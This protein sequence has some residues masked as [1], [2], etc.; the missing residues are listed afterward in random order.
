MQPPQNTAMGGSRAPPPQLQLANAQ[1]SAAILPGQLSP[2]QQVA[3]M[4]RGTPPRPPNLNSPTG[5]HFAVPTGPAINLQMMLQYVQQQNPQL[6]VQDA[7]KIAVDQFSRFTAQGNHALMQQHLQQ[8]V[9]MSS[10]KQTNQQIPR[11]SPSQGA[12]MP[13]QQGRIP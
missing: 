4:Q 1:Q 6:S 9:S 7:T 5:T 11:R 3:Q 13:H 8:M 12:T 10:P 2:V